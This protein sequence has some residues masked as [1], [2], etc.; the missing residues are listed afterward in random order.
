MEKG[1]KRE[2]Q[3][4][5]GTRMEEVGTVG[6]DMCAKKTTIWWSDVWCAV[7]FVYSSEFEHRMRKWD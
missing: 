6:L 7:R 5:E 1:E 3:N 2:S 4:K